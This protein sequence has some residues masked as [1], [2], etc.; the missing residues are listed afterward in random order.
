MPP[1]SSKSHHKLPK[2]KFE[3]RAS[4]LKPFQ[5]APNFVC[6]HKNT[7]AVHE[8]AVVLMRLLKLLRYHGGETL[9]F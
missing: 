4:E 8:V 2:G 7:S 9:A 1:E 5:W 6:P 3:V